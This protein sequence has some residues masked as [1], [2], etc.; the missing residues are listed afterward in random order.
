M[1]SGLA[2]LVAALV[3]AGWCGE[4]RAA[5]TLMTG[6]G[7][8]KGYG[9]SCMPPNDD[10]S[11]PEIDATTPDPNGLDITPAFPKGLHFYAGNY[12]RAWINNNGNVSFNSALPT[13][14][15]S[16]FPGALQPMIAPYWADVDTRNATQCMDPGYPNAAGYPAGAMCMNPQT[17]GVWWSLTPGQ[18]VVTWDSVGVFQCHT[19]PIMSFQMI[20][21]AAGCS[22]IAPDGGVAGIDFDIEFRYATCGWEAGDASGGSGGFC[23]A[24]SVGSGSCTPA[25][26]GFDSGETPDKD[27]WSLPMSRQ[28]GVST[29]LCTQSNLNPAQ[30]GVW[31]FA[32]RGGQ[33]Q[34]PTAGQPCMTG[35]PGICAQGLIQCNLQG[36]TM[37][38]P[39]NKPQPPQCNGLDNDCNGTID[40]G[41]CP[42]TD[43]CFGA[44]CVPKCQEGACP[45][46]KVCDVVCIDANCVGV[47]CPQGQW[48]SN[49]K[50][51]DACSGVK[52]PIGQ[53]CR[54]G[55][56]V[57]PCNGVTCPMNQVCVDGACVPVCG[58]AMCPSNQTCQSSGK[59]IDSTCASVNCP[60]GEVCV[61]GK[62]IDAC[63]G[64]VCPMDQI[65]TMGSCVQAPPVP[66]DAG[67]PIMAPDG[68]SSPSGPVDA[69]AGAGADA[70]DDG[71][72]AV[73]FGGGRRSSG[74]GCSVVTGGEGGAA[75]CLAV[76]IGAVLRRRRARRSTGRP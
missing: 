23:P 50:C 5:A 28:A 25:Q 48:C 43:V 30:P 6:L 67:A 68:G 29:E 10:G 55:T 16:A 24:G 76:G 22:V 46:G 69:S 33:L 51:V 63:T 57:D 52:C 11:W 44:Q 26:A 17:N 73:P 39:I 45:P 38:V 8:P 64:A 21:T 42:S 56:C 47:S 53:V 60:A 27:Y 14:T 59:C 36:T 72:Y 18:M 2:S 32:V 9:S 13:F 1:R 75:L 74:C 37:C 70:Q 7:G 49:G 12:A 54:L 35:Q 19:T 31:R 61:A 66:V 65:C 40:D 3:V 41:P 4:A 34:C 58:C 71:G 15:P 62:C 20:L